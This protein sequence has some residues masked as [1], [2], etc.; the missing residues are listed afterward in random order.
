[1]AYVKIRRWMSLRT[2]LTYC[3]NIGVGAENAGEEWKLVLERGDPRIVDNFDAD[4][5]RLFMERLID[6]S[7]V[8][9]GD[10]IIVEGLNDY[11]FQ[12]Q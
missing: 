12:H 1:M 2:W 3:H 6:E 7:E 4:R 9:A 10:I 5:P 8:Q 11:W